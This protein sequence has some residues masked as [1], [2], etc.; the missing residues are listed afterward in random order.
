MLQEHSQPTHDSSASLTDSVLAVRRL[1]ERQT[2]SGGLNGRPEKLQDVSAFP[3]PALAAATM[4]KH[5]QSVC[6]RSCDVS[7]GAGAF[8]S[9][10]AC[11]P[12]FAGRN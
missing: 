3:K 2:R 5:E 6:A 1:C 4:H 10:I 12:F 7:M 9:V 8:F 11:A